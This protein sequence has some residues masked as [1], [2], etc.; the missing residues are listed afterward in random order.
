MVRTLRCRR[1]RAVCL[2]RVHGP[3]GDRPRRG[4]G[5]PGRGQRRRLPRLLPDVAELPLLRVRGGCGR[6]QDAIPRRGPPGRARPAR[7]R[8]LGPAAAARPGGQR[9]Q[10]D[11]VHESRADDRATGSP[12]ADRFARPAIPGPRAGLPDRRAR[13][14]NPGRRPR[15]GGLVADAEPARLPVGPRPGAEARQEV[16]ANPA[17][18]APGDREARV[19]RR[20]H[21]RGHGY[22]GYH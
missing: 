22:A 1:H 2:E 10:L 8:A 12:G 21:R 6:S 11:A 14:R 18:G 9:Q 16:P 19:S 4:G 3:D 20:A 17:P 13:T 15:G 5:H 7:A